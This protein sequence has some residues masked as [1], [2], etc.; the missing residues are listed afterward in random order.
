MVAF[1]FPFHIIDGIQS[2]LPTSMSSPS[3]WWFC[4]PAQPLVMIVCPDFG[5]VIIGINFSLVFE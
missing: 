5:L 3:H 2:S 1:A 4:V